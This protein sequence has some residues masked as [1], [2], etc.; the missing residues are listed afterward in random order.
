MPNKIDSRAPVRR[1]TGETTRHEIAIRML[2]GSHPDI[3]RNG[4]WEA[5][6]A[7]H[8]ELNAGFDH[9]HEFFRHSFL[10]D[11][12]RI[13]RENCD[14]LIYEVEDS[15][16][17]PVDKLEMYADM[18]FDWD[19]EGHHDWLPRLFT[20]DRYGRATGEIDLGDL[21]DACTV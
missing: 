21:H 19:C 11:A 8:T 3:H 2:V 20:I 17:I 13:D 6:R 18:W 12:Y 14:L 5:A 15:H 7:L 9:G 10:P 4:F 16:P 1:R